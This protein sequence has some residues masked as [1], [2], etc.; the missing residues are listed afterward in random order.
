MDV[1]TL[2]RAAVLQVL[3]VALLSTALALALGA[4]FA[5]VLF[6]LWCARLRAEDAATTSA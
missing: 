1:P 6:A 5:V 3:A 2:W 4:A